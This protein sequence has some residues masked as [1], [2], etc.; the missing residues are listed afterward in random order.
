M[1][2]ILGGIPYVLVTG[3]NFTAGQDYGLIKE[4]SADGRW[5]RAALDFPLKTRGIRRR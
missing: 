5:T 2:A 3:M 1:K 4:R